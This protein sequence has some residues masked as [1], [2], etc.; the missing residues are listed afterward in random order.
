MIATKLSQLRLPACILSLALGLA[1]CQ[2]Q[3]NR[4]APPQTAEPAPAPTTAP[5]E[6]RGQQ[7]AGSPAEA[8]S[9]ESAFSH[10]DSGDAERAASQRG[11]ESAGEPTPG[12]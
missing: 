4:P 12:N 5:A 7:P 6:D 1:A 3:D 10:V 2:Q 8:A 11:H 9:D